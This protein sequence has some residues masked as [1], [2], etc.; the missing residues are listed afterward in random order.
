MAIPLHTRQSLILR[1]SQEKPICPL[2]DAEE[3]TSE[4]C[5]CLTHCRKFFT[6]SRGSQ[7]R[8]V[9]PDFPRFFLQKQMPEEMFL[10]CSLTVLFQ[11]RLRLS[12]LQE[13]PVMWI[14]LLTGA[15]RC[16][17]ISQYFLNDMTLC[18]PGE[19]QTITGIQSQV[20]IRNGKLTSEEEAFRHFQHVLKLTPLQ[21]LLSFSRIKWVW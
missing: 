8:H 21:L 5:P 6:N 9:S 10:L 2:T 20:V 4:R 15:R 17:Q 12:V 1:D 3:D 19:A 7:S 16:C 11:A 13:L 14:A 18:S